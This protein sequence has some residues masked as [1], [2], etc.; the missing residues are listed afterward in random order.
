MKPIQIYIKMQQ[1]IKQYSDV[2][3][4]F[5]DDFFEINRDMYNHRELVIN[6]DTIVRWLDVRKDNLKRLLNENF[7]PNFDYIVGKYQEPGISPKKEQILLTPDCFKELCMLSRTAK[8]KEVRKYFLA[9]ERL[10]KKYH[11]HIKNN[12]EARI[13]LLESN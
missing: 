1:F 10:I 8:A 9:V 13:E 5:I 11:H 4:G 2:P 6:F 7:E 3:I 12:L